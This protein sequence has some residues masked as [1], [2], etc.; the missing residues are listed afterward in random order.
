MRFVSN[1]IFGVL[2]LHLL[3]HIN[4]MELKFNFYL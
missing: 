4:D 1:K 2:K 3:F